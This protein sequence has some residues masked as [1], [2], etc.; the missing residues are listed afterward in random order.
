MD[1]LHTDYIPDKL[2]IA[3]GGKL[4]IDK[5]SCFLELA[6]QAVKENKSFIIT[7]SEIFPGTYAST[8]ETTNYLIN[9]LGLKRKSVLKWGALGMQQ[10]SEVNSGN[11][12]VL[13]FAGNTAPDHI[14]HFHALYN[15]LHYLK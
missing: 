10:T 15:Y 5:L 12:W 9:E 11:F 14:D 7:H 8:T 2:T 13:G 1:G 4:N 6:N 3:D